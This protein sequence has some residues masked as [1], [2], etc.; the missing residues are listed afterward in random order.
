MSGEISQADASHEKAKRIV[1][2]TLRLEDLE[3]GELVDLQSSLSIKHL[4]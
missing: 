4:E 3:T 2:G 1:K